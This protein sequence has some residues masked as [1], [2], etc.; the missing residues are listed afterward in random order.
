MALDAK[1]RNTEL[2]GGVLHVLG[3]G[4]G[5]WFQQ[6]TRD[7]KTWTQSIKRTGQFCFLLLSSSLFT[8]IT[9]LL[10]ETA[11]EVKP[12]RHCSQPCSYES[13]S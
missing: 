6:H 13:S 12:Q 5:E 10:L 8:H 1:K 2:G 4:Q 11:G 3:Q 9:V 7:S